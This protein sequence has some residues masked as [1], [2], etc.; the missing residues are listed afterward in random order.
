MLSC[1]PKN[2]EWVA[3]L[4]DKLLDQINNFIPRNG[5]FVKRFFPNF[6]RIA[7]DY[8]I[9]LV[10]GFPDPYD[11]M[12]L[13]HDGKAYMV[14]DLIQ[15]QEESLNKNYSCHRVL[16]HELIHLCLMEDYPLPSEM[17]YTEELNYTAFNE[18]FAHALTFSED[19]SEFAFDTFL[20]EK[21]E[22][23]KST[24][25]KAL[26]ETDSSKQTIYKRMAD[27]GEY[28][29]KFAA[30]AGKLYLLKNIDNFEVIY[31]NGWRNFTDR[32]LCTE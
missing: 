20:D 30:M 25:M 23:A 4:Y 32:I 28:W 24:L 29:N 2:R 14:F 22:T 13:E 8:T 26:A 27:T 16:T 17:S 3:K 10:V 18:G 5:D 31:R 21:F 15:F 12:V 19:I 7:A 6:D 9:L 1:D 11:A